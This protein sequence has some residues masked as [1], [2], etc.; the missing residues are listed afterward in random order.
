MVVTVVK[1]PIIKA[2]AV[3]PFVPGPV[4]ISFIMPSLPSRM[5]PAP[6]FMIIVSVVIVVMSVSIT[7]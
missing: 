3:M 5:M 4:M 2:F 7:I 1:F 6:I